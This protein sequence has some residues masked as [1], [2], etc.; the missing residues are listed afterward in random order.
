MHMIPSYKQVRGRPIGLFFIFATLLSIGVLLSSLSS[1]TNAI[2]AS[3]FKPGYIISDSIFTNKNSMS[4]SQVQAFLN[5]KMP[6]CDTYG[7]K[8]SEFGGGTRRQWAEARGYSPPYTCLRDYSQDGKSAARIIHDAAQE[9]SINPQVIIVLLQKEQALVTDEWPLSTQYR[10]ATGYGCPDT[11]ACDSQ[12]YGFTNQ[13]RWA[14]RMFRAIMNN[15]PT[16]YTPYLLGNNQI[17]W[18]PSTSV[19]GYSTVNIENRAT[20][21]LYNY[22]PYRPNSAALNAGFGTG[23]SCSSYGNRNFYLYFTSWF[24]STT[25]AYDATIETIEYYSDQA[26][27]TEL[28][29]ANLQASPGQTLYVR[30]SAT[31]AGYRDWEQSFTR[32]ATLDPRNHRDNIFADQSWASSNRPASMKEGAVAPLSSGTFEFALKM[33]QDIGS[34]SSSFGLVAEG[35]GWMDNEK[36]TTNISVSPVKNY[37]SIV[38][39]EA[40]FS[41][42]ALT[43]P[44]DLRKR[45]VQTGTTVFVKLTVKN[46]GITTLEQSSYRVATVDPRNRSDSIFRDGSWTV[47]NRPA[48]LEQVSIA[49]GESGNFVFILRIPEAEGTHSDSFGLVAEG[50]SWMDDQKIIIEANARKF[51]DETMYGTTLYRGDGLVSHSGQ[52]R[53]IFQGDGNL[54]LYK[55]GQALWA[56]RTNGSGAS[57]VVLQGD[58]NLVL[59]K[60]GQALW[61]SRTNGSGAS[62]LILQNDGNLVLYKFS[63]GHSW[64]SGTNR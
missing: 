10:T 26:M 6:S 14:A 40:V 38:T 21:A 53:L 20:Q 30:I 24:G 5:S 55:G 32:V 49:S 64:A 12:Y 18:H 8:A 22:T 51:P 47:S 28:D 33:P 52:Y 27:T 3:A 46:I 54:V 41:D 17:P 44:L 11:A 59:Y 7:T 58:G 13:V 37:D 15:T 4:A 29:S 36:I 23:N 9:F 1:R 57:R 50:Y 19:C 16:W 48:A 25:R 61:S 63:G 56:S 2:D 42:A 45:I 39:E 60:G 62:R 35:R 43:R 34:F 31:N